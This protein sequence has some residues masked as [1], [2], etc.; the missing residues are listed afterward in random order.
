MA[1]F[2]YK[3]VDIKG[4]EIKGIIDA[5]DMEAAR[6]R[7]KKSGLYITGLW[8]EDGT[9][10]GKGRFVTRIP[11]RNISLMTHNFKTLLD[12]G[13]PLLSTLETLIGQERNPGLKEALIYVKERVSQGIPLATAMREEP[14]IFSPLYVAMVE[15]GERSGSLVTTLTHL[16]RYLDTRER[17]RS[18]VLK[19]ATYPL[20]MLIVSTLV[21]FLLMGWVI[22][23]VVSIFDEMEVALPLPTRILI[24]L[25]K[26]LSTWWPLLLGLAI[27][28]IYLLKG[29]LKTGRGR[30]VVE[31]IL[32]SIPLIGRLHTLFLNHTLSM[33]L[34]I[35]LRSGMPLSE[36][37]ET[38][39]HVIP[40]MGTKERLRRVGQRVK[41]GDPLTSAM[42]SEG[43]LVDTLPIIGTGERGGRLDEAFL[44]ASSVYERTLETLTESFLPLLEPL[45]I[46]LMGG[47][48]GYIVI[49]ILLPIMEMSE[50]VR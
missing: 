27:S 43:V 17:I 7:L 44:K 3:G 28:M 16:S 30:H 48:V 29:F 11:L 26:S 21:L 9:R 13:L 49:S 24:S 35:L 46:I 39:L 6:L 18:K 45:L 37:L 2:R 38:S 5:E 20:L 4:R 33:T 14:H 50:V 10:K 36:A 32:P 12:S 42:A 22:P 15:V 23:R 34:A 31:R 1:V 47:V 25:S 40:H 19:A 8:R 41:E